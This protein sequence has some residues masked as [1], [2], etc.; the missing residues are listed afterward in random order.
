MKK[1]NGFIIGLLITIFIVALMTGSMV[2]GYKFLRVTNPFAAEKIDDVAKTARD[3]TEETLGINLT[4]PDPEPAEVPVTEQNEE[5]Y[6]DVP[7]GVNEIEI[8]E[9]VPDEKPY[10]GN[11][12]YESHEYIFNDAGEILTDFHL[13]DDLGI[14][15]FFDRDRKYGVILSDYNCFLIKP[16]LTYEQ[17]AS[18]VQDAGIN[19]DGTTVFYSSPKTGLWMYDIETGEETFIN[20]NGYG[21][22][23]SPDGKTIVYYDFPEKN[24]KTVT[25]DRIGKEKTVIELGSKDMFTPVSVSN[26]GNTL[27]Y[28]LSAGNDNGL[29][30]YCNGETKRI[31][32]DYITREYV[33]RSGES[34][35]YTINRTVWYY[36]PGLEE[37]VE[38]VSTASTCEIVVVDAEETYT[39]DYRTSAI[40]DIDNLADAVII[41]GA[42]EGYCL[43]E[44]CTSAV[45][46]RNVGYA[47][48]YS[49]TAEGP[50]CVYMYDNSVYKAVYEHG[51]VKKTVLREQLSPADD[52][53][54]TVGVSEGFLKKYEYNENGDG[55]KLYYFKE[56]EEDV[57]LADC[58]DENY[59][60][61]LWDDVFEKCYF[62]ID[63]KLISINKDGTL[64]TTVADDVN[65]LIGYIYGDERIGYSD[66]SGAQY[67]VI[68][69]NVFEE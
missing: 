63:R 34:I 6:Q 64:M 24:K 1:G 32:T 69:N 44:D 3:R 40:V 38:L 21:P 61:V 66:L 16:D 43:T 31:A 39:D 33:N 37:S 36:E 49:M 29:Y 18:D 55:Y 53:V 10:T 5:V 52:I 12:L 28:E 17:I 25:I 54:Y 7:E 62:T 2:L 11:R 68:N 67:V 56:G 30:C 57:F 14:C 9:D 45:Q 19:Y 26:D 47:A 8:A 48:K 59:N 42:R 51:E 20:D 27:F 50:A 41:N 4:P 35:L 46:L 13:S 58:G 23:I 65:Y 15:V 60:G 22:C